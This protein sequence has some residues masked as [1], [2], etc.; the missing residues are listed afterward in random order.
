M[1]TDD[2][3]W[4]QKYNKKLSGEEKREIEFNLIQLLTLMEEAYRARSGHCQ[5]SLKD[6][7]QD[8][9]NGDFMLPV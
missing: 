6:P 8:K 9:A 3:F 5:G 1:K 4:E 2:S 7:R